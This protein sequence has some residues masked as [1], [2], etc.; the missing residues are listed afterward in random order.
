MKKKK[1]SLIE[2]EIDLNINSIVYIPSD[3]E[4]VKYIIRNFIGELEEM[5]SPAKYL[6]EF[7][8][9]EKGIKINF[10]TDADKIVQKLQVDLI[11]NKKF[12]NTKNLTYIQTNN[13]EKVKNF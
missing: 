6:N 13:E 8:Y 3:R 7:V 10:D 4:L 9:L 2:D 5:R 1:K 11:D 12:I